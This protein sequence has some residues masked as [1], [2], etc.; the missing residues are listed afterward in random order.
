MT[1]LDPDSSEPV[2]KRRSLQITVR[3]LLMGVTLL[4]LAIGLVWKSMQFSRVQVELEQLRSEVGY[5]EPSAVD[6]IAAVRAPTNELLTYRFRVRVPDKGKYRIAYSSFW[7]GKS[8]SP[9]WYAAVGLM[10]GESTAI[11]R[12]GK[13]PR[14]DRWKV[15]TAIRCVHGTKRVATVLPDRHAELFR[16]SNDAISCSIGPKTVTVAEK[17]SIRLLDERWIVG[18]KGLMLYGDRSKGEDQIGIFAELQ[19]DIGPL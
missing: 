18:E 17:E 8:A 7:P 6:E 14:D 11:V 3:E 19:P 16:R 4:I 13:D 2:T 10:P 9:K 5:L 15:S 1:D 12:V